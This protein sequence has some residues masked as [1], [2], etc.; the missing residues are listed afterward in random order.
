MGK[1]GSVKHT[2][3]YF[4]RDDGLWACSGIDGCTHYMPR[5]MSPAPVGMRSRCWRCDEEFQL[6]PVNMKNPRPMCDTCSD[7]MDT[8]NDYIERKLKD[9][10]KPTGLA[11]FGA[12]PKSTF[13]TVEE[14]LE[15]SKEDQI[16]SED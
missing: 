1:T 16:E 2:H 8:L 10:P 7:S 9:A 4:R 13:K 6:D 14:L 3:K 15:L 5:N 11:A 12:K